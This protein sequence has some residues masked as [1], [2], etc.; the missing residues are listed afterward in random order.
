MPD[1][2]D[3][4]QRGMP[5]GVDSAGAKGGGVDALRDGMPVDQ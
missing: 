1:G 4:E 2:A 3:A 5:N